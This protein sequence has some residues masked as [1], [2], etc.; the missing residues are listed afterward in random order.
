MDLGIGS[1]KL[2]LEAFKRVLMKPAQKESYDDLDFCPICGSDKFYESLSLGSGHRE[3]LM[4][5]VVKQ[6]IDQGELKL[7][8]KCQKC[9][10][11]N[12]DSE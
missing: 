9:E 5:C 1:S 4:G 2:N 6:L 11:V 10:G 7:M 12:F 3:S 8:R